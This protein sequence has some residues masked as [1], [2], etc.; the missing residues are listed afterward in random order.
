MPGILV[1]GVDIGSTTAK[2]V[3]FI[4]GELLCGP[5]LPTGTDT[6]LAGKKALDTALKDNQYVTSD[7][8]YTVVTGYGRISA[9]FADKT[10]T[11]ITCH[12][13]GAHY[14]SPDIRTVVDI[15][16]QDAKIVLLGEGGRSLILQ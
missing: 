3:M 1:A 16:G 10:V 8:R 7:L 13:R 4:N 12:G 15:G 11:E 2:A 9:P 5:I 14:L 6:A